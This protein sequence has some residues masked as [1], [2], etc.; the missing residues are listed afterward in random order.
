LAAYVTFKSA[1]T[2]LVRTVALENKDSGLTANVILPGTMDT[3][4]NRKAMPNADFSKWLKPSDVADV[5]V[6]LADERATHITGAAI[7]IEGLSFG[8]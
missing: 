1:L 3:P 2:T 4:G 5:V 6:W 7:P 8:Q